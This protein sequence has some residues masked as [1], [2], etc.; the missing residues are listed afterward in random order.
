MSSFAA[1]LASRYQILEG[2]GIPYWLSRQDNYLVSEKPILC[3]GTLVILSEKP[4]K[5]NIE[6]YKILTGM[7]KVLELKNDTLCIAW[8]KQPFS[9]VQR[10][11]LF[12]GINKFS[13]HSVLVMGENLAQSILGASEEFEV[14]RNFKDMP[15]LNIPV[16]Y[17]YSPKELSINPANKGKAYR[18][19]LS[20]KETLS[21]MRS[22]WS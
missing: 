19:L 7:L 5:N 22:L 6:E 1:S 2:M 17:T 13:P 18:D 21:N 20:L 4:D 12:D 8:L 3:A 10:S 9:Q 15:T 16:Q 14:I 11:F